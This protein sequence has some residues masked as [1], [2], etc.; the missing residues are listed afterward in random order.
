MDSQ[1]DFRV[2][3][4]RENVFAA[5]V[6]DPLR[7]RQC[8]VFADGGECTIFNRHAAFD[9][10]LRRNYLP[11]FYD[12]ISAFSHLISSVSAFSFLGTFLYT[13]YQLTNPAKIRNPKLENRNKPQHT[14]SRNAKRD[15]QTNCF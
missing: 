4:T 14:R 15:F 1:M 8:R 10:T 6:D 12:Q 3:Q 9:N 5:G 2:D 13:I 11:I 7:F